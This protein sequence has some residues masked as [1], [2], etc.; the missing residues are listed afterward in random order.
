MLKGELEIDGLFEWWS[1]KNEANIKKHHYSFKELIAK[2]EKNGKSYDDID[3][4]DAREL[5]ESDFDRGQFKYYKPTKKMISFRI[6]IDNLS[7]LQSVGK[8]NCQTRLNEVL[9]W[10]R[11][12]NCPLK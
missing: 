4:S 3:L 10:A 8:E 7:W 12:N 5:T 1:D 9:R 6:D 2:C 11:M